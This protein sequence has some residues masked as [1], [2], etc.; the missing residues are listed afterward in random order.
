M[1]D[2]HLFMTREQIQRYD[3]IAIDDIGIPGP[4]L[5]ENAGRGAAELIAQMCGKTHRIAVLAG[6][7]NNGGDGFVIARH[8]LNKGIEVNTYLAVQRAKVKG[9]AL[10]NLEILEA[11]NPPIFDVVAS[12]QSSGLEEKLR[13]DGF[14][15]DALLG[16]G[17][18]RNV[19]GRLGE[20]IDVINKTEAPVFAVDIPSGLDADTG[21]PWGKTVKADATATFGHIKRGLILFPGAELAGKI[22][23][24]PLGVPGFVSEKAGVDGTIVAKKH[25]RSLISKRR[26]DTHKGTFGHLLVVAGAFGKTGAAAMVGKAAMRTGAGLV[27]LATT[28]HAQHTLEAKC[29]EVMVDNIVEKADAPLTEKT[30]KR[31]GQFL[32]GKQAVA[33]GPGLSTAAGISS[34]VMRMLNILEVPAVID[35]D[36]INILAK[37]PSGAGRISAPMVFTPH[38]GEMARLMNKTVP[39]VQADRIGAARETSRRQQVVIVLKG[40][41]TVIAAPDGRVFVNTTGNPGMATGGMGDVLTGIIG[42][43]LA[44]KLDP[45]DA[46]LLGVYIHGLAGDRAAERMGLPG[47]IASDVIN[48]LPFILKQWAA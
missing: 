17:V 8:L 12:D 38:P 7:G 22:D 9:D 13:E 36:G 44:Q 25:L 41:H 26:P 28:A 43:F 23:V 32:E 40:A 45:L 33:V 27:T 31:I 46:A 11:M 14:V 16:T 47:L 35:A 1:W 39:A 5:M 10:I 2:E 42:S 15:V 3:R 37:D 20:L 4:V 48:E 34:L 30:T 19:E 18:S 21:R 29:M 6:P 24:V